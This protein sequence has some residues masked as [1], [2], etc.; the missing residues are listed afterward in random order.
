MFITYNLLDKRFHRP[1]K[2]T[3]FNPNIS[4]YIIDYI[5]TFV[6]KKLRIGWISSSGR[7]HS[8]RICVHHRGG[9]AITL[10]TIW[11]YLGVLIVM[12]F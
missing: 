12:V 3:G 1:P 10:I 5:F 2:L 4:I 9:A 8:G 7:N 6:S 11:T